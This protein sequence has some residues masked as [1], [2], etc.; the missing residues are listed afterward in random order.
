M[1]DDVD[2]ED[3]TYVQTESD[4]DDE[5]EEV[6]DELLSSG[7]LNRRQCDHVQKRL[8][9]IRRGRAIARAL[10]AANNPDEPGIEETVPSISPPLSKTPADKPSSPAGPSDSKGPAAAEGDSLGVAADKEQTEDKDAKQSN[11][12]EKQTDPPKP[13]P[14]CRDDN[15][16][17]RPSGSFLC[18]LCVNWV[19]WV[20][21][22]N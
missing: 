9:K 12:D 6:L 17:P 5:E 10:F 21:F 16:G 22:V 13:V 7:K 8:R 1:I 18:G 19:G 11:V 15:D 2:P 3:E 4:N 14:G 20:R